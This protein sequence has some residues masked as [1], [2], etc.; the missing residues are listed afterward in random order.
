MELLMTKYEKLATQL[1]EKIADN[2]Q[3]GIVKLPTEASLCAQYQVSRQTVRAALAVLHDRGIISSIQGSGSFATG[4]SCDTS[5]NTIPIL[6]SSKQEYIYPGLLSDINNTLSSHGY[7]SSVLATT[8]STDQE[9]EHLQLL[10]EEPPRGLIVEGCKSAL[11]N[12][13]L[14]LY[15]KLQEQGTFLLFLHNCY[16]SLSNIVYVKDDN[17]YGGRLLAEYLYSL[18]HTHFAGLFKYDDQQGPERFQGVSAYLRDRGHMLMDRHVCWFS[19]R[20]LDALE[21]H[22]DTRFLTDFIHN[23]LADCTAVICYN[24]EIA[25]W[26]IKELQYAGIRVPEDVSVVCFDNSYLSDLSQIRISTLSHKPHEMGTYAAKC[27]IHRLRGN[28][29]ASQE[30]PWHFVKKD[31]DGPCISSLQ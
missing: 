28:S 16:P 7:Y 30:I 12:P 18:G 26:L 20:D 31:S 2:L 5:R 9:R 25:Y 21:T 4:L 8:N 10:L 27:M 11:P 19:S 3:K 17:I 29:V 6:I 23:Y 15:K 24:D 14:D 13:N 22:Q 1:S